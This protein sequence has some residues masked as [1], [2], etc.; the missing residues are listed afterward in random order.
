MGTVHQ[1][2]PSPLPRSRAHPTPPAPAP[3]A[4]AHATAPVAAGT[5]APDAPVPVPPPG[6]PTELAGI[7]V[8]PHRLSLGI[9]QS[10]PTP[11]PQAAAPVRRTRSALRPHVVP[12]AYEP[13]PHVLA[14]WDTR[15][16]AAERGLHAVARLAL[17]AMGKGM[18]A[19][20]YVLSTFLYHAEFAGLPP[21]AVLDPFWASVTGAVGP[22]VLPSRLLT[23]SPSQGGFGLLPL[24]DHTRARHAAT[25][26]RLLG[27]LLATPPPPPPSPHPWLPGWCAP[28][29]RF[30]CRLGAMLCRL[31]RAFFGLR[32]SRIQPAPH[33][34]LGC[35]PWVS[36]AAVLLRQACP[37]LHPAQ[38]LLCATLAAPADIAVGVLGL[39][40]LPQPQCLPPGILTHIAVAFRSVGPLSLPPPSSA[41]NTLRLLT[42]AI[43]PADLPASLRSLGWHDPAPGPSGPRPLLSPAAAGIPVRTFTAMLT[44]DVERERSA[45]HT[46]YV[47]M[48]L[49]APAR[50]VA[51]TAAVARFRAT[52]H[53]VWR[54]PCSNALKE[55][56]W[57]LAV[58]CTRATRYGNWSCPA[59]PGVPR[60]TAG[61]Q[62]VF[63]DCPVA[64][65]VRGQLAAVLGCPGLAQA[66][67]WLLTPP[68]RQFCGP[69]W[70]VVCLAALE[71]MDF[72]RAFLWA[73]HHHPAPL[74]PL[75][76]AANAAAA[77]FWINLQDFVASRPAPP[78]AWP[79]L[80]ADHPFLCLRGG[81]LSVNLPPPPPPPQAPFPRP[82]PPRAPSPPAPL[83]P[84]PAPPHACAPSPLR[85]P[86]PPS[87]RGQSPPPPRSPFPP[88]SPS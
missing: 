30:L 2:A 77:R 46:A 56:L 6:Q 42:S 17:S 67:V 48:A 76:T 85:A 8:V 29:A 4:P 5:P 9:S 52:L 14:A 19:A 54:L 59:C 40:S 7:P 55:V 22:G 25:G 26:S 35:P 84:S 39:P 74:P 18:A 43:P 47:R 27:H 86:R 23:G 80:G 51:V 78:L 62:H 64:V 49:R 58:N 10:V 38:T 83:A 20:A 60:L 33:H 68:R 82:P 53:A 71:A 21:P 24:H 88:V 69:V 3:P 50:S 66:S 45:R 75:P 87:P 11:A 41:R 12:A 1:G 13:Q 36:L 57:R 61:R 32:G 31:L 28:L 44:S 16:A 63:W 81:R 73:R 65:A 72:G 37:S 15:L 70:S 79:A 34:P